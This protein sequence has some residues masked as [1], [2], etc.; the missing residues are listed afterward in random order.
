MTEG[1]KKRLVYFIV[2]ISLYPKK[3]A[4][5]KHGSLFI[6]QLA[7]ILKKTHT[8]VCNLPQNAPGKNIR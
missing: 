6:V 8:E 5:N 2:Y 4:V 7:E 1:K 3:T